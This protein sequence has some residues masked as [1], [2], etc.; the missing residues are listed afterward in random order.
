MLLEYPV[1]YYHKCSIIILLIG[2]HHINTCNL[3]EVLRFM[4]IF[5]VVLKHDQPP[6][7]IM[8]QHI[9]CQ[10]GFATLILLNLIYAYGT[11]QM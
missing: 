4:K 1:P 11:A 5:F 7:V 2:Y 3:H 9:I 10:L 8:L 6:L